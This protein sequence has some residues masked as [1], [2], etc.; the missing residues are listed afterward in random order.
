MTSPFYHPLLLLHVDLSLLLDPTFFDAAGLSETTGNVPN[1][2]MFDA[3]PATKPTKRQ[4]PLQLQ[5]L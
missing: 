5:D 1:G 2:G 4:L 3:L